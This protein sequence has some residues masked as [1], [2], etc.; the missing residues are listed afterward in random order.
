MTE[1][2]ILSRT[3][4]YIVDNF[5]YMRKN[6]ELGDHDSL[7]NS[8]LISSLGMIEVVEWIQESFDVS[9]D[10]SEITEENF[11]TAHGISRFITGKV[12][13]SPRG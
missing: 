5:M 2:E 6:K 9:V 4:A 7:L 8:G 13:G 12:H 3:K 1:E 11:D 10:P